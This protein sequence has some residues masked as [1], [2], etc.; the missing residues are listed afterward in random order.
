MKE[1]SP[2]RVSNI[3]EKHNRSRIN[4]GPTKFEERKIG[5][6]AMFKK[7]T[8]GFKISKEEGN[9]SD[10]LGG[11][12]DYMGSLRQKLG[13]L[14]M[15]MSHKLKREGLLLEEEKMIRK[16]FEELEKTLYIAL[17]NAAERQGDHSKKSELSQEYFAK[18]L[19]GSKIPR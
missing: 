14:K 2:A 18:K 11:L 12:I 7:K 16:G 17:A 10:R 19:Y 4:Q 6:K 8:S 9:Q 15:D 5:S 3:D 13:D 1:Y